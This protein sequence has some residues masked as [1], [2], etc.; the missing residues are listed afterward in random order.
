MIRRTA[1]L[2]IPGLVAA[3][4][5]AAAQLNAPARVLHATRQ[6]DLALDGTATITSHIE[7]KI[8]NQSGI[9]A[10]G[11]ARLSYREMLEELDIKQAYT[12]K[13]DGQ[14]IMVRPEAIIVQQAPASQNAAQMDDS[15]QKVVIYPNLEVGDVIVQDVV[16]KVKPV[17]AGNYMYD[18]VFSAGLAIDDANVSI[19]APRA[20]TLSVENKILNVT[21]GG[22]S[23]RQTLTVHYEH[24]IADSSPKGQAA[25]DIAPRLSLSTFRTYDALAKAY[26]RDAL[27][28]AEITPAIQ[29]K[30]DQITM[31]VRDKREQAHRIYDWVAA[32]IRYVA[33][34]FGR[35]GIIPHTADSV[36]VNGYGDCKDHTV[37]FVALLK[38]KGIAANLVIINNGDVHTLSKAP[39]LSPFN[40]MITWLPELH[41]Y[42]DTTAGKF[43]PFGFLPESE[44]GKPVI[45]IDDR[46]GALHQTP[47][48]DGDNSSVFY[49][50]VEVSDEVGHIVSNS[51]F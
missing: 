8:L 31:G 4:V 48:N 29:A 46:S 35:G 32:H 7:T 43:A 11:Q 13:P 42:A 23:D 34:E 38:A 27:P 24:P 3:T 19:S 15:K 9:S 26:A 5:P 33:L 21:K 40:H 50:Q 14:K 36:M 22:D 17:L 37:L 41:L 18:T 51:E 16:M 1:W 28:A 6:I 47:F 20:M 25:F 39:T 49:K 44:Y 30:A 10:L 45:H 2:V 12:L